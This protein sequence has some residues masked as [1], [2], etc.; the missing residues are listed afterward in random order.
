MKS[1]AD[2]RLTKQDDDLLPFQINLYKLP[3]RPLD[4]DSE[5]FAID[6]VLAIKEQTRRP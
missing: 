5:P 4:L 6:R 1:R 3:Y 2:I